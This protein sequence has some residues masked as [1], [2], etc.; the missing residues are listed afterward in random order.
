MTCQFPGRTFYSAGAKCFLGAGQ[1]AV[2]QD[3]AVDDDGGQHGLPRRCAN[4]RDQGKD[5]VERRKCGQEQPAPGVD[6]PQYAHHPDIDGRKDAPHNGPQQVKG[7]E[8][9]HPEWAAD[10][11]E[12]QHLQGVDDGH[13]RC[14]GGQDGQNGYADRSFLAHENAPFWSSLSADNVARVGP[15][16]KD[17]DQAGCPDYTIIDSGVQHAHFESRNRGKLGIALSLAFLAMTVAL[18]RISTENEPPP[19]PVTRR[20]PWSLAAAC[21]GLDREPASTLPSAAGVV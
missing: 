10:G 11:E 15:D 13:Q 1:Q 17:L 21:L 18:S 4:D 19:T 8:T 16:A 2:D 20:Q 7:K 3:R 5:D 14:D 6:V 9:E 12:M